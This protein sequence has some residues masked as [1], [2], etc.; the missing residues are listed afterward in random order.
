MRP[1]LRKDLEPVD[2]AFVVRELVEPHFDP[3]W[4]FHPHYQLFLV[5][6][7]TGTRFIGDSIQP[8]TPGDL[9]FLGP[10]LPHLWRSDQ[11]YFDKESTRKTRG[12]VVYFA[13][14][15]MDSRFMAKPEMST[16]RQFL[17]RAW[18]GLEWQG[19]SRAMA[20]QALKKMVLLPIGFDRVLALLTLL[21]DL[22]HTTDYR[23]ITSPEYTNTLKVS[24]ADERGISP[25]V[26]RPSQAYR[27]MQIVHDYVLTHYVDTISLNAVADL[28]GMSPTAFCRYFKLR[29]NKTFS[30]FVTEVRVGHARKLLMDGQ[31]SVTQVSYE[32]GFRTL[33]NFN[34]QFK[35]ITGQTPSQYVKTYR[36]L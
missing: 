7:G 21:N 32:S 2:D 12:L 22:S 16:L 10:N 4:H 29:A 18:R 8:F 19:C 35:A 36:A 31:L 28:A 26:A 24:E 30:E 33:S 13:D 15:F 25:E 23:F 34:R 3:N 6:E 9:V 11:A 1:A 20:E 27:R 17:Q 5:E 14:D